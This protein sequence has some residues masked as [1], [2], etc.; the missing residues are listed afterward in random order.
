[1]KVVNW[2][3][4]IVCITFLGCA[5]GSTGSTKPPSVDVTGTWAG[6]WV[7]NIGSGSLTMTLQQSGASVTGDMVMTGAALTG[8]ASNTTGPVTGTVSGDECSIYYK[9]GITHLT[10]RGNEMSGSSSLSRWTLKRR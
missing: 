10:V 2:L 9:G 4:A 5:T 8:A 3:L 1:M 7:G 6:D